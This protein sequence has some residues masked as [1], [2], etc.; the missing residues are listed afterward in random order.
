MTTYVK[1]MKTIKTEKAYQD[2]TKYC[3]PMPG[4]SRTNGIED[5]LYFVDTP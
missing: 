4:A 3:E 1:P 5:K 2:Q